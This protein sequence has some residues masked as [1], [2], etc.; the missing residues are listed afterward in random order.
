MTERILI[1]VVGLV[2]CLL[3]LAGPILSLLGVLP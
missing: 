1:A 2:W 3:C